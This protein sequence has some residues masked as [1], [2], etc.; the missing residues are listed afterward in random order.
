MKT[1]KFESAASLAALYPDSFQLP[2]NEQL[3]DVCEGMFVKLCAGG[4]RFWVIVLSKNRNQ[5]TGRIDNEL[6]NSDIH[7]LFLNDVVEF[8]MHHIYNIE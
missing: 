2:Q 3:E 1:P 5:F 6:V 4:E 8:E 7:D